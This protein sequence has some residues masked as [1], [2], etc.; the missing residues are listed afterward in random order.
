MF[1]IY[2]FNLCVITERIGNSFRKE[3]LA[4]LCLLLVIFLSP[5][6]K[7]K[8]QT[9]E[10]YDWKNVAIGGGG[11]VSAI[12]TSKTE[13]NLVYA[14]TDVG[15]AYR[16]NASTSSWVPLLD[17]VSDDE[18]GYLIAL[19]CYVE[20]ARRD[21]HVV[22]E[23]VRLG[24][25]E[26]VPHAGLGAVH[27]RP[28]HLL[29]RG[30][31]AGH[32]L[33]HPVGAEVHRGVALDHDDHVAERGDVG[34]ARRGRAEQGADLGDRAAGPDLVPEDL[35]GATAAGEQVDLVG[36]AG[37][38]GV[39]QVDHRDAG[40]VGGLRDHVGRDRGGEQKERDRREQSGDIGQGR[41]PEGVRI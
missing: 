40:A 4:S 36:D 27:P 17:W 3:I 30:L 32:H 12:I 35:A 39:D 41:R 23:R 21:D 2:P 13:Q 8:A 33:D 11:F 31:L 10:N 34:A 26:E 6:Y 1:R 16:W 5:G 29:Q 38:G 14:R 22:P 7:A 28:A 25:A 15:G 9:T 18:V 19:S 37:A 20:F 24:L